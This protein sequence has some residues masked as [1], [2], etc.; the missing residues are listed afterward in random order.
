MISEKKKKNREIQIQNINEFRSIKF[1][2]EIKIQNINTHTCMVWWAVK[3]KKVKAKK[4]C[5]L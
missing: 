3:S 1:F 5:K 2:R 4:N